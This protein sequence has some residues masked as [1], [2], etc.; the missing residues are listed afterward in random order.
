[1]L[2]IAAAALAGKQ[3]EEVFMT[4]RK[5]LSQ[6]DGLA[7]A[8]TAAKGA[9]EACSADKEV[10]APLRRVLEQ[11]ITGIE[12][13]QS[14]ANAK[15]KP[16][17]KLEKALSSAQ[18]RVK[19]MREDLDGDDLKSKDDIAALTKLQDKEKAAQ[20]AIKFAQDVE[21]SQKGRDLTKMIYSPRSLIERH[22]AGKI[23]G[24]LNVLSET[25]LVLTLD[26]WLGPEAA[27]SLANISHVLDGRTAE[28]SGLCVALDGETLQAST[29]KKVDKILSKKKKGT[30]DPEL[31]N[32]SA[33]EMLT[34]SMDGPDA[35]R[36]VGNA[37][38][39]KGL[40]SAADVLTPVLG[41][42]DQE[43]TQSVHAWMLT[44]ADAKVDLLDAA[45]S[46]A[47]GFT[48]IEAEKAFAMFDGEAQERDDPATLTPPDG[49]D[50]DE[51]GEWQPNKLPAKPYTAALS[52]YLD[53]ERV[54]KMPLGIG[55][56]YA[57]SGQPEMVKYVAATSGGAKLRLECDDFAN[58]KEAAV[59]AVAIVYAND[60]AKGKGGE[61]VFPALG[62][63][64]QPKAGRLLLFEAMMPDGTCDPASVVA[65]SPLKGGAADKVLVTK[66]FYADTKFDRGVS[67]GEMPNQPKHGKIMCDDNSPWGCRRFEPA[68]TPEDGGAVMAGRGFKD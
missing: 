3:P 47:V 40:C 36:Q 26:G 48:D 17:A 28:K 45:I 30:D 63:S 65:S 18:S 22:K 14:M 15:P 23:G 2:T 38:Q 58:E 46:E 49:W 6:V 5:A 7:T 53:K 10:D 21:R 43:L 66:R 68:G 34:I 12:L 1:M 56:A 8:L 19:S 25:P 29:T 67:E 52:A 59:A 16:M 39:P 9:Q 50:E 62:V 31:A 41:P 57:F 42:I 61:E 55:G 33:A 37:V 44:S 24:E 64:V 20:D 13:R 54:A 32:S 60:V 51:D 11:T 4:I 27:K 35:P